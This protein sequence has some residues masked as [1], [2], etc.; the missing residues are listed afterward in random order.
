MRRAISTLIRATVLRYLG[1]SVVALGADMGSFL[2][3]LHLGVPA[4][5]ASALAYAVG[6]AVHWWLSAHAVFVGHVAGSGPERLRQQVMFVGSALAGLAITTGIVGVG[7]YAGIDP[8]IAKIIAV[9][10]SFAVTYLLRHRVVFAGAVA[11]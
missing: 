7:A 8:R 4:A 2:A 9:G 3:L 1:A 6:M 5:L 11:A 10:V